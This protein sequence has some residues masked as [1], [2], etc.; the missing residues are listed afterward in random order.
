V[1]APTLSDAGRA[2]SYLEEISP[3]MRGCAILTEGR[4]ML[5]ASD[6]PD[7]WEEAGRELVATADAAGGVPVAHVHVATG[8]GE[9]FCVRESGLIGVAVTD[10]FALASLMFFDMRIALRELA[11]AGVG[12]A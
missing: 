11:A 3:Q 5:A 10:R 9:A 1:D 7:R 2:V 6:N 4:V 8:D 12:A